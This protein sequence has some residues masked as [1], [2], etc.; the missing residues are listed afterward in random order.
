MDLFDAATAEMRR[1]RNQKKDGSALLQM[2]ITSRTVQPTEVIYSEQWIETKQRPI[3]GLPEESSPLKGESPLPKKPTRRSRPVLAETSVNIPRRR[4][5]KAVNA[6]LGRSRVPK[7]PRRHMLPSLPSSSTGTSYATRSRFSP[8]EDENMEFKLTVGGLAKQKKGGNFTIFTD[9]DEAK[10]RQNYMSLGAQLPSAGPTMVPSQPAASMPQSRPQMPFMTTSWLQPQYQQNMS[11]QSL[12]M[13]QGPATATQYSYPWVGPGREH[14]IPGTMRTGGYEHRN[15]PLG[16]ST[17][18]PVAADPHRAFSGFGYDGGHGNFSGL[19]TNDDVFGY[20]TNPLSAFQR[21]GDQQSPFRTSE[22]C[23]VPE[24]F[25]KGRQKTV[26][27][28]GTISDLGA[29]ANL[30][31]Y[32]QTQVPRVFVTQA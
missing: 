9:K 10:I 7:A 8:T 15:N 20:S 18:A 6:G 11:Y 27:P 25:I 5:V 12:Y 23:G 17:G 14:S 16:W 21:F 13:P 30:E 1:R 26:S 19:N 31:D 22:T 28:D 4:S 3:T 24:P 2:E 32:E 29:D